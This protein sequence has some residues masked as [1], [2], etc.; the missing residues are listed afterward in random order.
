MLK[1]PTIAM[2]VDEVVPVDA[3][4]RVVHLSRGNDCRDS[5]V[6]QESKRRKSNVYSG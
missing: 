1:N 3:I 4:F 5:K 2:C 6:N